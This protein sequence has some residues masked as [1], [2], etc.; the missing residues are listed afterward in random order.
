MA[1]AFTPNKLIKMG[2]HTIQ[3]SRLTRYP[4]RKDMDHLCEVDFAR[5]P[6]REYAC[7]PLSE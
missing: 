3:S 5:V 6:L 4:T 1:A 2:F 7:I